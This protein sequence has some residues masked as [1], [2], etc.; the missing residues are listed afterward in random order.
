M[1]SGF[2]CK[3]RFVRDSLGSGFI[4]VLGDISYF[5]YFVFVLG[6][7]ILVWVFEF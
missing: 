2:R 6:L 4:W 5:C 7:L 1:S 3:V